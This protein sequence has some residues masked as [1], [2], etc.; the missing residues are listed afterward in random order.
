[1]SVHH[2]FL[3][4]RKSAI[5]L[6]LPAALA[7]GSMAAPATAD[8]APPGSPLTVAT[9]ALPTAQIGTGVVWTQ[10][11]VGNTVYVGGD[12]TTARDVGSGTSVTR[13]RFLAFDITTG[14][15]T[16][17]KP[18]FD[19]Q[20]DILTASPDGKTLYAGGQFTSVSGQKRNRIAAF[21]LTNG[22]ALTSFA[23][24]VNSRVFGLAATETKLY[25]SGIFT[26]VAPKI[27]SAAVTRM[28]AA[29]FDRTTGAVQSF[30]V[31]PSAGSQIR[32]IIVSPAPSRSSVVLGGNF[33]TMNRSSSPGYGL[34]RVDATT[35]ANQS[36]PLN[37]VIR[38]AGTY[39]KI[40]SLNAA[41]DGYWYGTGYAF[42]NTSGNFEG[43]FK[44]DWSGNLIWMEDCHGD[45]YSSAQ[46]G[47]VLYVAGHPH[48]CKRISGGGFPDTLNPRVY[49]N[50]IAFSTAKAGTLGA[51]TTDS[52]YKNFVGQPS[53]RL[54]HWFP[55][56]TAGTYTGQGQATWSVV[57]NSGY[58]AYGGEFPRIDGLAQQGLV[59]F[60]T[61]HGTDG[62][63]LSSTGM[64][65]T[66]SAVGGGTIRVSLPANY[67]RDNT[68]L[69]YKFR[70]DGVVV[71]TMTVDSNFWTRPTVTFN[72]TGRT[73]G[74]SYSYYVTASDPWGNFKTSSTVTVTAR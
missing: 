41:S 27:G 16:S 5:L 34:A 31:T 38:D 1:M 3:R 26:S 70:R 55:E 25:A 8:T 49:H 33:T 40:M 57:A 24:D 15:L 29:A 30:K 6:I 58:V 37:S 62:P 13:N 22:G 51:Y 18:S 65:L 17:M 53:P 46:T 54:L 11:I 72:D 21:D 36:L 59:R 44:A 69:T 43:S 63:R 35:G 60:S 19:A 4:A 28:N 66:A 39:G 45:T 48:D 20:I 10:V 71:S 47:S 14:R 7:L 73:P 2:V 12:F 50:G 64:G 32:R 74:R 52:S 61:A 9:Q 56:F 42:G 23:P 67:D 68:R